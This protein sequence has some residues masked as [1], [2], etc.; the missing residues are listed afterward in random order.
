VG[1]E[2]LKTG[3]LQVNKLSLFDDVPDSLPSPEA[4]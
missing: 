3:K 4:E 1:L 2:V